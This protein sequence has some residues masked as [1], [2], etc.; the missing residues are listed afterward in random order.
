ML[1]TKQVFWLLKV[2]KLC[3]F[4]VPIES[5]TSAIVVWV[6]VVVV[7]GDD[8]VDLDV[9]DVAGALFYFKEY[10]QFNYF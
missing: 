5:G 9:I 7:E 1:H 6:A 3:H 10:I 8:A 2:F 4:L